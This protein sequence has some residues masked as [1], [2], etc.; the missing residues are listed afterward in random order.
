MKNLYLK[1][2]LALLC[3]LGF[4]ADVLA[5]T[6]QGASEATSTPIPAWSTRLDRTA[7]QLKKSEVADELLS[8]FRDE[9]EVIRGEARKWIA[10]Q[11]P[12]IE[13][14]QEELETLG[15][16]PGEGEEPEAAGVA[17]QRQ[18]LK[19]RLADITAPV[20]EAELILARANR[21]IAEIGEIRRKRFAEK[22]MARGPSPLS[23]AVWKRAL[24]EMNLITKSISGSVTTII[25]SP[26]FQ[27]R[28]Q[29]SVFALIIAVVFAIILVWPVHRWLLRRYGR[30]PSISRPSFMQAARATLVVG[31]ARALLPTAA[32]ALIYIVVVSEDLLTDAGEEIAQAIFLGFVL[33]TWII[34]FFRASLS[35][36]QP[37]WRIVPV[38]TN[39]ARG[40]RGIIIGL[41]LAFAVDIV[42][43]EVI[44]TYS[45]RLAVTALRDYALTA[46][47]TILLL[48]LMLRQRMW[49]PED[50]AP[51]KPRWR[52]LRMLV[53]FGLL[54]LLILG[55]FG[56]VALARLAVTQL[57]LT[58]GLILLVLVLHRLGREFIRHAVSM[59]TWVGERL[60]ASLRMDDAS[61][62]RFEFWF[63][64]AYDVLLVLLGIVI[65]LFVWGADRKDV[66]DWVYQALFGFKIG[67]ITFSLVDLAVAVALFVG[68]VIATRFIQR[69]LAEQVFPQTQLD[70]GI[71][72]SI[73][74][75]IGYIGIIIAA[76]VGISAL[77]LDLSNLAILAGALS[78]GIGFGLQNVVNNFVSGLILL[79]E[80]PVKVGDWVVVGDKQ[81]YVKRIKVRATE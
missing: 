22:I 47:V 41:A 1:L 45:A 7:E 80:R 75:A 20:K 51:R 49:T 44:L 64:L 48:A 11:A 28:L 69:L 5:Q 74:S 73:R 8:Q 12:N 72:Q 34:A 43:S 70:A 23:P 67:Q 78:V 10:E 77:G 68:L 42:L 35:P 24:P 25:A 40:V 57:V 50:E 46:V 59:E 66:A 56:Y 76:A 55:A 52:S 4:S 19:T 38:P 14:T 30:D 79:V 65:G 2:L 53:A 15:P 71:R 27:Q 29:E 9:L 17:A 54:I 6:H 13:K 21:L 32:A 63:G 37:D 39:F 16:P 81:G 18:E 31:A 36:L 60:R 61:V 3:F 58:G 62:V 33:F 26:Q